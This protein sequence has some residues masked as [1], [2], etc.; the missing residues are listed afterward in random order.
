M[1][2]MPF[3]ILS[4]FAILEKFA[5]SITILGDF[6]ILIAIL[7]DVSMPNYCNTLQ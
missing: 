4:Y 6:V 1:F 5:M 3:A 2:P 7:C